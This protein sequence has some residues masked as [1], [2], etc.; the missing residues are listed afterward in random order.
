MFLVLVLWSHKL[1]YSTSLGACGAS[2]WPELWN[3][4]HWRPHWPSHWHLLWYSA[5]GLPSVSPAEHFCH[6]TGL[7]NYR[8]DCCIH[9]RFA[10]LYV[11]H[12]DLQSTPPSRGTVWWLLWWKT[13]QGPSPFQCW[14][15]CF[16]DHL[17][18]WWLWS[19]QPHW[20]ICESPQ[21]W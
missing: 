11:T 5:S 2:A 12:T 16:A 15:V 6:W 21:T 4:N 17:I 10:T 3:I 14:S 8:K 18:L 9:S 1:L 13:V 7:I 20:V 19:V